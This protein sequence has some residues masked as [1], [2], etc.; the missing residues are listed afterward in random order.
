MAKDLRMN[1]GGLDLL[2]C[3]QS[4]LVG[5]SRLGLIVDPLSTTTYAWQDQYNAVRK[6]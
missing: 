3:L 4:N 5:F 6:A 2:Q 1:D